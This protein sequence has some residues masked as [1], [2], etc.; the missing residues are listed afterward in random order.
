MT[1]SV[2]FKCTY[3]D[4]GKGKYYGF[5]GRCSDANITSNIKANRVWCGNYKCSCRKGFDGNFSTRMAEFPCIESRMF[6][7]WEVSAGEYHSGDKEGEQISIKQAG[8]GKVCFLTTRKSDSTEADRKIF[9]LFVIKKVIDDN[10]VLSQKKFRI[11]LPRE[12]AEVLNYWSYATVNSPSPK[13]GSGLFRY[14]E[15]AVVHRILHDMVRVVRNTDVRDQLVEL[16]SY[17]GFDGMPEVANG[18]LATGDKFDEVSDQRKY[19][20]G[21]EGKDHKKLKKWVAKHPEKIGLPKSAKPSIEHGFLSGDR[22][23][24]VFDCGDGKFA[25]VEIETT[26]PFPGAYQAIKYRSLL[27]AQKGFPRGD[28]VVSGILVAWK[29]D[30]E[31][32]EFCNKN[33]IRYFSHKI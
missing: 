6:I 1:K 7:D 14:M 31:V 16:I 12:E 5:E 30:D 10:R 19:G 21:G 23:D 27:T 25:A 26:V 17:L 33:D 20:F 22:A 4:G 29:F 18:M 13:W 15:D 8:P 11:K 3:N 9:G 28:K 24:I 32:I 2:A